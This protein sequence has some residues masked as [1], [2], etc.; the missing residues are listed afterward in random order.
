M[1]HASVFI[2][3]RTAVAYVVQSNRSGRLL[4]PLRLLHSQIP[5][6]QFFFPRRKAASRPSSKDSAVKVPSVRNTTPLRATAPV[7]S[8]S[9]PSRLLAQ[10]PVATSTS[11]SGRGLA[12]SSAREWVVVGTP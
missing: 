6:Y 7:V 3:A 8:S 12:R 5:R 11:T 10:T 9:R 1:Q 4:P 2:A